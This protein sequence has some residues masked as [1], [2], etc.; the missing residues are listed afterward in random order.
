[1][2]D[3]EIAAAA[4]RWVMR[5]DRGL[6]P[7]E[8]DEFLHW[9]AADPRHAVAM[10]RQ[11]SAWESFDRLAGL[12][13]SEEAVPD[14]DLLAP[15]GRARWRV[16][17]AWLGP[18]LAAAAAAFVVVAFWPVKPI[19]FVAIPLAAGFARWAPIEERALEDGS[20]VRLNRGAEIA[21]S[22]SARE[23]RIELRSGEAAFEVAKDAARPFVVHSAGV[24]VRA[25]GTAFNVRLGGEAVDVIVTEGRV[26][27]A[28]GGEARSEAPAAAVA[29]GQHAVVPL[30]AGA[31]GAHVAPITDEELARRLAWQPRLL[32][33]TDESLASILNEFNRHNALSLRADDPAVQSLRLTARFRSDNVAGFLRLLESDCNLRAEHGA[34]GDIV[35]HPAR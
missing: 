3:E 23:R 22:F 8:Q 32:T 10:T 1:M 15:A 11:R 14:P 33:F 5:H 29:A 20:I 30:V 27:V 34:N 24:A 26:L 19:P 21:V 17:R 4:A 2:N 35:L 31:G 18:V 16:H 9:L 6:A 12:Q 28:G 7:A 25:V 13:A